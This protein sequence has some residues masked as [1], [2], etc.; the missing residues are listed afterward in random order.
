MESPGNALTPPGAGGAHGTSIRTAQDG[1][2][3]GYIRAAPGKARM[4]RNVWSAAD[5]R[6][7]IVLTMLLRDC[8]KKPLLR[9]RLRLIYPISNIH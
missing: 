5:P 1:V 7:I 3:Y 8:G 4:R 6:P 9:Q 2:L